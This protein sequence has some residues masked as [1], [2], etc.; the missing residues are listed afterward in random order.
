[1]AYYDIFCEVHP[2]RM[3]LLKSREMLAEARQRLDKVTSE[4]S[5]QAAALLLTERVLCRLRLV[6]ASFKKS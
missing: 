6:F 4:W 5:S 2:K 1:M 3:R